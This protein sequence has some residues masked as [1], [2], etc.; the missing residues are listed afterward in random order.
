MTD[1][2]PPQSTMGPGFC[3][4]E[5]GGQREDCDT[6]PACACEGSPWWAVKIARYETALREILARCDPDGETGADRGVVHAVMLAREALSHEQ[7]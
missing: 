5:Y 7:S 1:K 4:A 3:P 2:P 6:W